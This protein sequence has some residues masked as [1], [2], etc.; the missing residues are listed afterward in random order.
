[1]DQHARIVVHPM[2]DGER[3]VTL[4]GELVGRAVV[5]GDVVAFAALA[6]LNA[7]WACL[8]DPTIVEWRGDGPDTWNSPSPHEDVE[9]VG[10]PTE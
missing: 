1:M 8:R 10:R 2:L 9:P 7:T 6:G 5:P 3:R 4:D